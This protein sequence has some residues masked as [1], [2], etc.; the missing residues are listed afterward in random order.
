MNIDVIITAAVGVMA[1]ATSG[2]CSYFFT[3]KKY[4]TE[5]D[6]NR[7]A[8]MQDSLAF[9]EKLSKANTDTLTSLLSKS[10]ELA[11]TNIK[12]L[13]EIQNLKAQ[14][15]ILT[16]VIQAELKNVDLSKYGIVITADN[17]V[18]KHKNNGYHKKNSNK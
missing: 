14:V 15:G 11:Q 18:E 9:Y 2:F 13:I 12:L 1:T 7:I 6:H 8:N 3:R 16:A 4:N 5:V 17:K 10:E